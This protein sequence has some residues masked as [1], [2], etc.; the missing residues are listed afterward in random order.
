MY[1]DLN[2]LLDCSICDSKGGALIKSD[3]KWEI[4][5][6]DKSTGKDLI[7]NTKMISVM[8]YKLIQIRKEK[9]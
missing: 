7:N 4:R 5:A 8:F 2:S 9:F 1:D 6:I 3:T